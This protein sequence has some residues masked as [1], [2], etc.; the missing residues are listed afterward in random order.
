M[1]SPASTTAHTVS[2]IL[3]YEELQGLFEK[4]PSLEPQLLARGL[5]VAVKSTLQ[6]DVRSNPGSRTNNVEAAQEV[7][8]HALS[9]YTTVEGANEVAPVFDVVACRHA[10]AAL[11]NI[12]SSLDP[13]QTCELFAGL[14]PLITTT[15]VLFLASSNSPAATV[16]H[17][18]CCSSRSAISPSI[19]F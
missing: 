13:E 14:Q 5:A 2:A 10:I 17:A 7:L 11:A 6:N 1:L 16:R 3:Q 9:Q 8:F 19:T 4:Y 18:T 12:L 15:G